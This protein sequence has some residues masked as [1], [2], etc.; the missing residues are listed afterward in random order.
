MEITLDAAFWNEKYQTGNTPWDIGGVSPPLRH[1]LDQIEDKST[2]IL[3][4]GAGRAY[5][6]IYL[7]QKGFQNVWVCD[8]APAAFDFLKS[9]IPD[10]PEVN[11]VCSDF[12]KLDLQVDLILEQT[13]FCAIEP[14]QRSAYAQKAAALLR[15]QGKLAGL[16]FA[17]TFEKNGPPF[18]GTAEE[19]RAAFEPY[20]DILQLY[21]SP[22]S[23]K[24][25]QGVE[26]FIE[27]EKSLNRNF[28]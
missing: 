11:L 15:P 23:I 2:S 8:W 14:H 12:F 20:F 16:L 13:F 19:Y 21:I 5:E 7:H 28:I 10:F 17:Q 9:K 24:P 1:Y 6:A 4:P 18:G 3:I 25:R 26:L 22:Y 27:L